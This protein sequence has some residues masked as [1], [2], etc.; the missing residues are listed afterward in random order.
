MDIEKR[1]NM[2]EAMKCLTGSIMSYENIWDEYSSLT[3]P[4]RKY[5]YSKIHQILKHMN[6]PFDKAQPL[7]VVE[8]NV[9]AAQENIDPAVALLIFTDKKNKK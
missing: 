5:I 9:L 3:P 7:L 4:K 1:N 2:L 6:I 8:I